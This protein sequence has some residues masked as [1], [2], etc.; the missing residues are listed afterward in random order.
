MTGIPQVYCGPCDTAVLVVPNVTY[1]TRPSDGRITV[2]VARPCCDRPVVVFM[3]AAWF[4]VMRAAAEVRVDVEFE[5]G[6]FTA[7]LAAAGER[8][9]DLIGGQADV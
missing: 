9:P 7:E 2:E 4:L 8:A 6:L 3:D 5:V 1:C